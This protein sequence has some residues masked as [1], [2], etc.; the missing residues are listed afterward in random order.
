MLEMHFLF[1]LA[2]IPTTCAGKKFHFYNPTFGG[3]DN[4]FIYNWRGKFGGER[5]CFK[6]MLQ[7]TSPLLHLSLD[8]KKGEGFLFRLGFPLSANEKEGLLVQALSKK[9]TVNSALKERDTNEISRKLQEGPPFARGEIIRS[10][11]GGDHNT[12]SS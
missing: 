4:N 2:L 12:T 7:R 10:Y 8:L 1:H 5:G 9:V 6:K 11:H 3:E